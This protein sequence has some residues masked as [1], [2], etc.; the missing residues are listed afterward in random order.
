MRGG[1]QQDHDDLR[2]SKR[3]TTDRSKSE[4]RSSA[5]GNNGDGHR[6]GWEG[7]G[8]RPNGLGPAAVQS[9][10]WGLSIIKSIHI[11]YK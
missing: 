3:A 10:F 5:G 4:N 1:F 8:D 7:F 6:Q 9:L 2:R 11:P